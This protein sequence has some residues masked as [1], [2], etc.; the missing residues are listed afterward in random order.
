V[1]K[2]A[3]SYCSLKCFNRCVASL[4]CAH[5]TTFL[6]KLT[7]SGLVRSFHI[8]SSMVLARR[9]NWTPRMEN[10]KESRTEGWS[11]GEGA[12]ITHP[13]QKAAVHLHDGLSKT[14]GKARIPLN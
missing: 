8:K 7:H 1:V 11:G 12:I 5:A 4:R 2:V 3:T 6:D 9:K 14:T 10:V 13:L